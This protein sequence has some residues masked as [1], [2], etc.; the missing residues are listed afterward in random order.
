VSSIFHSPSANFN[1]S[2]ADLI[3]VYAASADFQTI[4]RDIL[5]AV[6]RKS[7]LKMNERKLFRRG[8]AE[9]YLSG[10]SAQ[11]A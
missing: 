5:V 6:V 9:N 8:S 7:A 4:S 2:L 10:A 1:A 11:V 3:R